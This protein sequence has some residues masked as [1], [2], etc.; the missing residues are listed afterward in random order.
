LG[1][2]A[3]GQLITGNH[4]YAHPLF[5]AWKQFF[6]AVVRLSTAAASPDA[7]QRHL[8]IYS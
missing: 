1:N 3:S 2:P 8:F 7:G 4:F 5:F 6:A